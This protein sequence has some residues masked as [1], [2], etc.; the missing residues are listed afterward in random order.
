MEEA[1]DLSEVTSNL[2][3][4]EK[5]R[6][7]FKQYY[8]QVVRQVMVIVKDQS[9]AEDIAQDVFVKLYHTDRSAI[10]SLPG[11]LAKVAANTAYNHIRSE[12]RHRAR[13]SRQ[14]QAETGTAGSLE[15]EYMKAEAIDAVRKTLMQLPERDRELLMMKFSGYSYEEIAESKNVEKTSIGAWLARAKKRF[16]KIHKAE[17][18]EAE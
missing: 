9:V 6:Q 7:L 11:W 4:D 16:R 2:S 3:E 5:F 1:A 12:Q 17:R 15:D 8:A 13:K 10:G 14:E 18:T